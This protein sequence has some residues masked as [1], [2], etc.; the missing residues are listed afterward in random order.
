M[1]NIITPKNQETPDLFY[2][3]EQTSPD[4]KDIKSFDYD[5]KKVGSS[6]W[7]EFNACLHLF[8]LMNR[9]A[10]QY[11]GDNIMENIFSAKNKAMMA[12]HGWYG[13][14]DHPFPIYDGQKLTKKRI[15][16][17]Y[18]PN[19]S[20]KISNPVRKGNKLFAD[21]QTCSG[22]EAGRGFANE[23]IQ[24]LI[25]CFSCR[26]TGGMQLVNGK[27]TVITNNIVTYD[28]VLYPGFDGAEM[29]TNPVGKQAS[30]MLESGDGYADTI[31]K[32]CAIPLSALGEEL[33]EKDG[34]LNAY[35]ESF[36][37]NAKLVG[38][39]NDKAIIKSGGLY[40]YAGINENSVEKVRDF[41]R[42]FN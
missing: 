33:I 7:V 4:P 35:M 20:H 14:Q 2:F 22:T 11:I 27:P 13:E 12:H 21:I 15:Y 26:S 32:D 37:G 34:R 5:T 29:V 39:S 9:N 41:Y 1:T 6:W 25:P 38:V 42:S 10:R 3:A 23:I 24:G 16:S 18:M 28:W 30:L 40:I 36:D 19:R 31:T 17:V 8:E